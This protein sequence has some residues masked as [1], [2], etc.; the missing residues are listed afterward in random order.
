MFVE[1]ASIDQSI[2]NVAENNVAMRYDTVGRNKIVDAAASAYDALTDARFATTK[3]RA[4]DDWQEIL[5]PTF[6]G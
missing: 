2:D 3:G 4:V 1:F 6:N 5:G